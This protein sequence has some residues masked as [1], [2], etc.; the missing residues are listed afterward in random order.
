MYAST[1][2]EAEMADGGLTNGLQSSPS[3]CPRAGGALLWLVSRLKVPKHS[4]LLPPAPACHAG[5]RRSPDT[6]A[7]NCTCPG[8]V[9]PAISPEGGGAGP[10]GRASATSGAGVS[11]GPKERGRGWGGD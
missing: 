3:W 2:V 9:A 11:G 8:K 7:L 5:D 10:Q 6:G 1:T 4:S